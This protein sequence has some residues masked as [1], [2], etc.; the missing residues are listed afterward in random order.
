MGIAAAGGG[1]P[2]PSSILTSTSALE[3]IRMLE[4]RHNGTPVKI[5]TTTLANFEE[6]KAFVSLHIKDPNF[7]VL[8]DMVIIL[9]KIKQKQKWLRH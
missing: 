3:R 8:S 4:S 9:Q 2:G 1:T 7:G 6:V 5:G